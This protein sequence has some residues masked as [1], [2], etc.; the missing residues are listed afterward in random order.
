MATRQEMD[1]AIAD[2]RNEVAR[3]R[4][5]NNSAKTVI[6]KLLDDVANAVN[7][8]DLDAV[9]QVVDEYRANSDD[10]AAAVA[11]VPGQTPTP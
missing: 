5:I 9:R 8:G 1:Q 3:D 10:L 4:D 7:Q 11:S 6:E 2:L